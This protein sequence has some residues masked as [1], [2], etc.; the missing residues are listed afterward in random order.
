MPNMAVYYDFDSKAARGELFPPKSN[1]QADYEVRREFQPTQKTNG[2][3][4]K[5][6]S[7][8]EFEK[9]NQE[10]IRRFQAKNK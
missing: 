7:V 6:E 10:F 5:E 4:K 9:H 8:E 3:L 1:T 2:P